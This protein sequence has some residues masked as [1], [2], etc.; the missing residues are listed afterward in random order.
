MSVPAFGH[1]GTARPGDLFESRLELSLHR[2]HRPRQ[3]GICAT[4][5]EGAESIVLSDKYEDDEVHEDF[6]LY[7]GH[8]GRD[9]AT[10]KQVT[11]QILTD[12]NLGLA[13]SEATGLPVRV[14]RKVRLEAGTAAFRYEG[15]FRV[16]SHQHAAGKSGFRVFRFRLEPVVKLALVVPQAYATPDL[17]DAEGAAVAEA[18][19]RYAATVSRLIRDTAVTRQV[20]ALYKHRCQ[21]CGTQLGVPAG[22]YAEAAHIK[23]LGAPHHGPDILANVL[24]LCPN[25]HVLFDLGSFAIAPDFT[26]VGLAGALFYK[27]QHQLGAEFLAYQRQQMLLKAADRPLDK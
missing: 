15:L 8:G 4:Q 22:F 2:Q 7:T 10:G 6:I 14:Y 18:A 19:P 23:P 20:K 3:A 5:K 16:T 12:S 9:P 11:D 25:H 1:V 13:R 24:C 21:V 17:F 27:P 26:L